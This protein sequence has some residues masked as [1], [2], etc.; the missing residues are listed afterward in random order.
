MLVAHVTQIR[1][2]GTVASASLD[3]EPD[4]DVRLTWRGAV[5]ERLDGAHWPILGIEAFAKFGPPKR[6]DGI[7]FLLPFGARVE[8]GDVVR[9]YIDRCA[10]RTENGRWCD[11]RAGH[12]PKTRHGQYAEGEWLSREDE[13]ERLRSLR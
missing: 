2:R 3:F 6:G 8:I 1:N 12:Y 4:G 9:V 10:D 13:D 11:R 7:G 5:L